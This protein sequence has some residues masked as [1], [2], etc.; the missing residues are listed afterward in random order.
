MFSN[1]RNYSIGVTGNSGFLG[2]H[3]CKKLESLGCTIKHCP[4]NVYDLTDKN[5]TKQWFIDCKPEIIF[6]LAAK[7]GG[8]GANYKNPGCFFYENLQ[9]GINLIELSRIYKVK[10]FIQVGTV[11]SYPK[12]VNI[13]FKEE[14][15]WMGYPEETNSGYGIAKKTLLTMLQ[16]YR[17]QYNLN[18]IY[19]IPANLYGPGDDF[20]LETSHVIPALIRKIL[21]LKDEEILNCWGTGSSTRDFLYVDDCASALILA[22]VYYNEIYPINIGT[23]IETSILEL[24]NKI[25]QIKGKIHPIQWNGKLDGQP[26][27]VLDIS[28]AKKL[29]GFTATTSLD[30]GLRKTV[31]WYLNKYDN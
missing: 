15:L 6:H 3:L 2:K 5:L 22:C 24:I 29:F 18:G 19:L 26:R 12:I 21:N 23:G 4:H 28:N 11:C 13:P 14:N 1:L 27:R 8:I 31:E 20:D 25:F 16:T 9:M 7:V 10:K 30:D 17:Q